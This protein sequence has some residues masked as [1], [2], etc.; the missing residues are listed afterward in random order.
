IL[1]QTPTDQYWQNLFG[2]YS[3]DEIKSLSNS[4]GNLLPLSQSINSSLQNDPFPEKKTPSKENPRGYTNGSNSEIEVSK[5]DDWTAYH[6]YN[7]G[8]KIMNFMARRW[9]LN[10]SN[11][12][13]EELLHI[14]FIHKDC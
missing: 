12:D 7:R 11:E 5:N 4:L 8:I 13:I 1:P 6:I 9:K 14:S 2:K 10:L 3:P